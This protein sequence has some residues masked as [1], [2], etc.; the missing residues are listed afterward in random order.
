MCLDKKENEVRTGIQV[1]EANVTIRLPRA[2][3]WGSRPPGWD[4]GGTLVKYAD[5]QAQGEPQEGEIL[6]P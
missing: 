6:W 5:Y 3:K 4:S 1:I 2:S